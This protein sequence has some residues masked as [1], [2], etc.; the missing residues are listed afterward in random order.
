[1]ALALSASATRAEPLRIDGE[2]VRWPAAAWPLRLSDG[3][4]VWQAAAAEWTGGQA[5]FAPVGPVPIEPDGVI[6]FA[7]WDAALWDER[8]GDPALVGFTLVT[9]TDGQLEDAD[10]VLNAERF[11]LT[12][13][14]TP[15]AFHRPTTLRHELGH[16]LGLGHVS[17]VED[18][19]HPAQEPG[20]VGVV[21]G[22]AE[23][24]LAEVSTCCAT[25]QRPVVVALDSAHVRLQGD[26]ATVRAHTPVDVVPMMP[27]AEGGSEL[28]ANTTH[29]EAWSR[30]GQGV[31]VEVPPNM[32]P[33]P[34]PMPEPASMPEPAMT[35][36]PSPGDGGGCTHAPG[37]TPPE[38]WILAGLWAWRPRR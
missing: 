25:V 22:A 34:V 15:R 24:A 10:V 11:T 16:A 35:S 38:L 30:A 37:S 19:M 27:D 26:L 23:Q 6:A 18:L 31:V 33:E 13:T 21:D 36:G 17:V 32:A 4:L 5:A 7:E 20:E 8:V 9:R 1:L 28:P 14:V 3:P 2:A 29:V 12:D